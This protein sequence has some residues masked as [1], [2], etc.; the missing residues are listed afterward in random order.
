MTPSPIL[1]LYG[2]RVPAP[3]GWEP[4]DTG[5]GGVAAVVE[6]VDPTAPEAFRASLTLSV[7]QLG[8]A[9]LRTW[10]AS[11]E[12][13]AAS[14]LLDHRVLDREH[15]DV[16]GRPGGRRLAHHVTPSGAAVV[17]EQWFVVAGGAGWTLSA[18]VDTARYD[19]LADELA[20]SA[21]AWVVPD[22]LEVTA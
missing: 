10:Q 7:E 3:H 19:L 17:L 13:A 5:L 9:D 22:R 11:A 20:L 4:V 15:T 6:P 12:A 21:A 8:D 2:A 16:A 18:T 1:A 14:G